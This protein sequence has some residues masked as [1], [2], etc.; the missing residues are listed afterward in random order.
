MEI[1]KELKN[2]SMDKKYIKLLIN[3]IFDSG[4][5]GMRS[6][7]RVFGNNLLN[8]NVLTHHE[9]GGKMSSVINIIC[10]P[11]NTL[12]DTYSYAKNY[13]ILTPIAWIHHFLAGMLNTEYTIFDK[14]KFLLFSTST[15]KKRNKLI[16]N[17]KL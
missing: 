12:S 1:P 10:P 13:K 7:D 15:F 3:D 11:I 16:K 2:T 6:M 8:S 14:L 5:F 4:V 9:N 17:L